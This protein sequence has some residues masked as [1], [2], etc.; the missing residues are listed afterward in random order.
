MSEPTSDDVFESIHAVMHLHR[1]LQYR[2]LRD[3]AQGL[4][5]MEFKA[6]AYFAAHPDSTLSDLVAHSGRD[7]AQIARLTGELKRRGLLCARADEVDRRSLRLALSEEGSGV[8][9]QLQQRSQELADLGLAGLSSEEQAV[10]AGLL[11]RV[12]AGLE[13]QGQAAQG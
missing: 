11:G 2:S 5:H 8:Y 1:A 7:K 12:K 4:T 13:A 6:L 3:A 10:L 9:R